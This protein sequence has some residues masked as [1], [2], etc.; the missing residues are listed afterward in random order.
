MSK[1]KQ[2]EEMARTLLLKCHGM[3]CFCNCTPCGKCTSYHYAETL[4]NAGYRKQIEGEWI[5]RK[6]FYASGKTLVH[7]KCSLCGVYLAT[8]ANFCPN[9]GA[10]MTRGKADE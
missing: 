5:E 1:E 6:R 8:Q 4:Y 10:S 2:I 3:E 7:Y 9:C